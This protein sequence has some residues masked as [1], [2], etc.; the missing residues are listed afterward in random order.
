[1]IGEGAGPSKLK[2]I[3]ELGVSQISEIQFYDLI[4]YRP[5]GGKLSEKQKEVQERAE[6]Q[7][8]E[9]AKRMER[10]EQ[11]TEKAQARKA[12]VAGREGIAAKLVTRFEIS[13]QCRAD[14]LAS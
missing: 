4:R 3:E 2:K 7:M 10:E 1:M 11:A 13:S 8:K 9:D 14:E 6:K 5:A 12:V